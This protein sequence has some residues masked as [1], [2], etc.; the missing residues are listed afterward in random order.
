VYTAEKL[1]KEAV[2]SIERA[3]TTAMDSINSGVAKVWHNQQHLEAE[4]RTLHQHAE[5]FNQQSAQWVNS[6][7]GFHD[8]LKALGD[9]ENWA[10]SIE[11]DMSFIN[12]S[13][14][15]IQHAAEASQDQQPADMPDDGVAR[16]R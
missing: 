3:T 12:S 2:D 9:V 11:S 14:E 10:R 1:K 16:E 13:L 7:K 4:A 15:Q 6:F 8:S 5:Q